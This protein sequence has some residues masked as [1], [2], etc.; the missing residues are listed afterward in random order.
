MISACWKRPARILAAIALVFPGTGCDAMLGPGDDFPLVP[1]QGDEELNPVERSAYAEDAVRLALR[2]LSELDSPA[3]ADVEPP[4][5]LVA[6]LYNAL[7]RMDGFAHPARD[8]AAGIHTFPRPETREIMVRVDPAHEWANAWRAGEAQTGDPAVD[9]LVTTYGLAVDRFYRWTIGDYAVLR[10]AD[11]LN[12][13]ALASRFR[14]IPGI[15][16]AHTN[17]VAGD[18]N[19]IRARARDDG[20]RLDYSIGSGD[21]PSGCI[22]RHTWSFLVDD[23]GTVR[24]LGVSAD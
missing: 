8:S 16:A 19:D 9:H 4:A 20:W 17:G 21:C 3:L 5:A 1:D 6:S 11:P 7:V 15:L 23:Q 18:G 2:Y 24:Y 14:G 22:H 10:S 12:A 13:E